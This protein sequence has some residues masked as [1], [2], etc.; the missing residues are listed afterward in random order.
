M[1]TGVSTRISPTPFSNETTTKGVDQSGESKTMP[2]STTM[3]AV[4]GGDTEPLDSTTI[5]ANKMKNCVPRNMPLY[6]SYSEDGMKYQKFTNTDNSVDMLDILCG[7]SEKF[8]ESTLFTNLMNM[9][10]SISYSFKFRAQRNLIL[11]AADSEDNTTKTDGNNK[12][13]QLKLSLIHI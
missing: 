13:K 2:T 1:P 3:S 7:N 8:E 5:I 9:C 12:N 4:S 10:R 6:K 11:K